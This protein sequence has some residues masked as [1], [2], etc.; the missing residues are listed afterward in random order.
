MTAFQHQR[1]ELEIAHRHADA[2][3]RRIETLRTLRDVAA[4]LARATTRR[5]V[6]AVMLRTAM[7]LTGGQA[8]TVVLFGA[9]ERSRP[10]PRSAGNI[11]SRDARRLRALDAA[12]HALDGLLEAHASLEPSAPAEVARRS[13]TGQPTRSAD[14]LVAYPIVW[15]AAVR[16]AL[17]LTTTGEIAARTL[18]PRASRRRHRDGGSCVGAAGRYDVDHEIAL[19]LHAGCC[20][21]RARCARVAVVCPLLVSCDRPRRR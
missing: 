9:W 20:R 4:E 1:E 7:E 12:A 15:R 5:A 11:P 21:R 6:A 16:G 10:P 8:G 13:V 3:S 17:I 2:D 18:P 19:K 14:T